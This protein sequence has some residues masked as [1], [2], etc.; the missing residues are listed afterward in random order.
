M[1]EAARSGRGPVV[2]RRVHALVAWRKQRGGSADGAQR[3]NVRRG[4]PGAFARVD[5]S[6]KFDGSGTSVRLLG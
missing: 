4:T 1:T 6:T 3:V 2:G 5:V